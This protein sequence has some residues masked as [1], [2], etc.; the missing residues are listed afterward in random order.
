MRILLI[1]DD[2]E[3][4]SYVAR[5]LREHGHVVD[6]AA[7]GQDGMFLAGGGHDVL[8]VDRMLP[9]LDGFASCARCA[10]PESRRRCCS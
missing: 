9:G 4:A 2:K 6:H 3:A 8:I 1:E 7:T 10:K 5:S